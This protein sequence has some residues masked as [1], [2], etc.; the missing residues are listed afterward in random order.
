MSVLITSIRK[1]QRRPQPKGLATVCQLL[2]GLRVGGA[3]VL[4]ADIA[5]RL[6]DRFRFLFVC[7]DELGTLGL[8]L[9]EE[10][11]PVHVLDRRP[12]VDWHCMGRLANLLRRQKVDVLHAHQ[13]TPFFY[14]L[15]ARMVGGRPA[16]LFTEHGRHFPDFP[17][18]KRIWTNR[19]LLGRGDRVVAVGQSVRR[20]LIDNEGI[21]AQ[22]IQVVYNGIDLEAFQPQTSD[23]LTVRRELGIEPDDFVVIQV[24]RLDYLKDHAT[25]IRTMARL[26]AVCPRARLLLVG[27]GP[28]LAKLE[29]LV[30]EQQLEARVHFLGLRHDI[31]RLL[32]ASD[33]FLLTSIS[34]GIP[35]TLIEAMAA[36]L[37]VVSTSVGGVPEVVVGGETGWLAPAGDDAALARRLLCLADAPEAGRDLGRAG[38]RRAE[39]LFAVTQM[40]AQYES[41]YQEML[42]S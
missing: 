9:Q 4:A 40:H 26:L 34:E 24:A 23:R 38:R 6:R 7:L 30:Q 27:E 5:R 2:H 3:E 16:V 1:P 18:R 42:R 39:V 21:P 28:E 8:R 11:F 25:A 32:S 20:A 22:R 10:G 31:P 19:L 14:A 33:V 17:R 36:E 37:P 12:G 41:L 13:Y 15:A 35:V 29:A